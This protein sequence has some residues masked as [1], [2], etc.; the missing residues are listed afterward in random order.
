M[1]YVGQHRITNTVRRQIWKMGTV[2]K[3]Q[4][5]IFVVASGGPIGEANQDSEAARRVTIGLSRSESIE[6]P[7]RGFSVNRFHNPA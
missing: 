2:P 5:P 1:V 3:G 4:S 7:T 6:P